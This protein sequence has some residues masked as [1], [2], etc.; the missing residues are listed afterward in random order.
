MNKH[1]IRMF[2]ISESEWIYPPYAR[3]FI[4]IHDI[5]EGPRS[6]YD[7]SEYYFVEYK[8]D[9]KD[10]ASLIIDPLEQML[11]RIDEPDCLP[12]L[13]V[14]YSYRDEKL[15]VDI[16]DATLRE[17][18]KAVYEAAGR[19]VYRMNSDHFAV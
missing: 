11:E 15:G 10:P 6:S 8:G 4:E 3:M 19:D 16:K 17:V 9:P 13:P 5:P 2:D 1:T 18:I 12:D 14:L 7:F